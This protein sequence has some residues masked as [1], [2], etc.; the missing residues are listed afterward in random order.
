MAK[1]SKGFGE[2]LRQ[3]KRFQVQQQSRDELQKRIQQNLKGKVETVQWNE[4]E[5]KMSEVL[6]AFV[7]PYLNA[8]KTYERRQKMLAIAAFAWNIT[9]IPEDQQHAEIDKIVQGIV[10]SD[11]PQLEKDT[12]DILAELMERKQLYFANHRRYILDYELRETPDD[13]FLSVVSTDLDT[14]K[15]SDSDQ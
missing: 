6:E 4:G 7:K 15:I 5:I 13:F 9:L 11:N 10:G 8:A 2:L 3:Q 12:R 1:R 14:Q